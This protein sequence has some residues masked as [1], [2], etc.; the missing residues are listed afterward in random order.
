MVPTWQRK[1]IHWYSSKN[2]AENNG[3]RVK[4]IKKKFQVCQR[5]SGTNRMSNCS[6]PRTCQI[7]NIIIPESNR[8]YLNFF[9]NSCQ[10][11]LKKKTRS[12]SQHDILTRIEIKSRMLE[13]IIMCNEKWLLLDKRQPEDQWI[14]RVVEPE[15]APRTRHYLAEVLLRIWQCNSDVL[16]FRIFPKGRID[17]IMYED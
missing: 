3:D 13:Q 4:W 6:W 10:Q 11:L 17:V 16:F 1:L 8:Y 2:K 12:D 15:R 7:H 14:W 5:V 9:Q